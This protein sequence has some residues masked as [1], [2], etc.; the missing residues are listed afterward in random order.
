MKVLIPFALLPLGALAAGACL[1]VGEPALVEEPI[2]AVVPSGP[3][4]FAAHVQPILED[5]GCPGCH[6]A[7]GGSGGLDA[8]SLEGLL[9]GGDSGAVLTP[10]DPE[11]SYL[12]RRVRDGEMPQI[13]A[14]LDEIEVATIAKWIA[15]GA[16]ATFIEGTCDDPPLD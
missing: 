15:Q 11:G 9:A 5:H 8:T 10:C 6:V 4:S 7:G 14:L 12:Y 13:G 16:T 1:D 2:T 3:L